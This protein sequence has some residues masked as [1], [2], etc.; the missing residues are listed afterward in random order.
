MNMVVRTADGAVSLLVDEIGDVV[1]MDAAN[2]ERPPENLDPTARE[3]IRGVYKLKDQLL[4]ILDTE[5]A[6]EVDYT[7]PARSSKRESAHFEERSSN[8]RSFSSVG[9]VIDE[10]QEPVQSR[11][12]A[13][14]GTRKA[15]AKKATTATR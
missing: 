15:S 1:A 2:C 8:R 4:L 3:L 11:S 5:R 9:A 13:K 12:A 7:K 10:A 14:K 6:V